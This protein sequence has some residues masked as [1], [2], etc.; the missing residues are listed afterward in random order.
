MD[1]CHFL[2]TVGLNNIALNSFLIISGLTEKRQ[3]IIS[4][5]MLSIPAALPLLTIYEVTLY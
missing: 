1:V 4:L 2:I 3:D 5:E